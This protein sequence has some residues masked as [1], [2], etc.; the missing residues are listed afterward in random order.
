MVIK[1]EY[2]YVAA[3]SVIYK[4]DLNNHQQL[5]QTTCTGVRNLAVITIN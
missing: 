3:D 2:Y 4:F 1:D 5:A